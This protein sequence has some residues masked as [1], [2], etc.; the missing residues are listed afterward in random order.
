M[1]TTSRTWLRYRP[2][3]CG[4]GALALHSAWGCGRAQLLDKSGGDPQ[5]MDATAPLA[6]RSGVRGVE[7]FAGMQR[8]DVE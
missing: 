5:T 8:S 3:L 2:C 4:V 6:R 7:E 1:T